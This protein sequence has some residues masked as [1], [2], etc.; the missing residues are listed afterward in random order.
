MPFLSTLKVEARIMSMKTAHPDII[1]TSSDLGCSAALVA[2]GYALL[3]LDRS[4]PRRI[5]FIFK[6]SIELS[7]TEQ[8]FWGGSLLVPARQYFDAIKLLKSRIYASSS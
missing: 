6:G 4:N 8:D 7:Q 3:D 2:C 1:Y 5:V